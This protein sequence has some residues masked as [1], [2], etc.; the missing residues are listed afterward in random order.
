MKSLRSSTNSS[1]SRNLL[2]TDHKD[3]NNCL[4]CTLSTAVLRKG[5]DDEEGG[6][7]ATWHDCMTS[8][9]QEPDGRSNMMYSIDLPSHIL[10]E[11]DEN[12][13][14]S[15]Q[16]GIQLCIPNGRAVRDD[17]NHKSVIQYDG[18]GSN[19]YRVSPQTERNLQTIKTGILAERTKGV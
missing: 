2:S 7:D 18:D 5:Y 4:I 9:D 8:S 17:G 16:Q 6:G 13:T 11:R 19:I 15:S 3:D 1:T 12:R 10:E 14:M